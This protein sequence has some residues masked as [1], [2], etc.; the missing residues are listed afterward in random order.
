MMLKRTKKLPLTDLDCPI[1]FVSVGTDLFMSPGESTAAAASRFDQFIGWML[2]NARG[3][4]TPAQQVI[5]CGIALEALTNKEDLLGFLH[6][7]SRPMLRGT[8][9][10]VAWSVRDCL[11]RR[12]ISAISALAIDSLPDQPMDWGTELETLAGRL[13]HFYPSTQNLRQTERLAH[14]L[15][16]ACGWLYLHLPN[17]CFGYVA[18]KFNLTVLP[19]SVYSRHFGLLTQNVCVTPPAIDTLV[20]VKDAAC[21]LSFSDASS[22][23]G[24]R[25]LILALKDLLREDTNG[26]R[27]RTADHLARDVV[28]QRLDTI[29]RT[30]TRSGTPVDGLLLSWVIFLLESG[31]ARVRNPKIGT[32]GR[33]VNAIAG[34]LHETLRKSAPVP[35]D[36]DQD[37]WESLFKLMLQG[38]V[39]TNER[40]CALASF[41]HFLLTQFGID[42]MPW[43]FSGVHE[44]ATPNAN[45]LWRADVQSMF[46]LIPCVISDPRLQRAIGALLSIGNGGSVRAGEVR[47]LRLC[48]IRTVGGKLTIYVLPCRSHHQGK[49]LAARRPIDFSDAPGRSVIEAWVQNRRNDCARDEDLLF[50]DPHHPEKGFR[51]GTCQRL[52]N[53]VM[54]MATG[55]PSV[56]FHSLRHTIICDELLAALMNAEVHQ[57]ISPV[58]RVKVQ[59]GHKHEWTTFLSYFH[60]PES[61]IRHW[62]DMAVAKHIN[63]PVVVATWMNVSAETMR[64]NRHRAPAK[65]RYLQDLLRTCAHKK[66]AGFT[67]P[68]H[69]LAS[70]TNTLTTAASPPLIY[71]YF[72][73]LLSDIG[74]AQS[75][76]AIC[77]RNSTS[78]ECVVRVCHIIARLTSRL[79]SGGR[80]KRKHLLSSANSQVALDH[81][82]DAISNIGCRFKGVGEPHLQGLEKFLTNATLPNETIKMAASAWITCKHQHMLSLTDPEAVRPLI[83][84]LAEA[85]VLQGNMVVR[86]RVDPRVEPIDAGQALDCLDV[87]SARSSLELIYPG[88]QIYIEKTRTRGG[89]PNVYLLLSRR[90]LE[91]GKSAS[92][93]S[94]RMD[95]FHALM[96]ALAVWI[97]FDMT[98]KRSVGDEHL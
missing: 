81:A 89:C 98:T 36:L 6:A 32:V 38:D 46:A 68:P 30:L 93:A 23:S 14:V 27:I 43:L 73:R 61:V 33:Y 41:H 82:S 13:T 86:V 2:R 15:S 37:E 49:S 12:S 50:G 48:D 22:T 96:L 85:S 55:D 45:Y 16:D 80:K 95:R 51:L 44:Q 31:S 71:D 18:G 76:D 28:R 88:I 64:Q 74:N 72:F 70:C 79:E 66:I 58:H 62:I 42:P 78:E 19:D 59:A 40:R 39:V 24:S 9:L 8:D 92:P 53:Q 69:A 83:M 91:Y 11:R 94:C 56:S 21:D 90:R 3:D 26:D 54:R 77:S 52:L 10:H 29:T 4:L 60:V 25:W 97:E 1:N 35:A 63:R 65:D 84:M 20:Y 57:S 87:I 34:L 75:M 5:V 67:V 17:P 7:A 47:S